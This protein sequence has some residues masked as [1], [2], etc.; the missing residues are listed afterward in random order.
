MPTSALLLPA[1]PVALA[2]GV[3]SARSNL[4]PRSAI[5]SSRWEPVFSGLLSEWRR[6]IGCD[7]VREMFTCSSCRR[8]YVVE[9]GERGV[10]GVDIYSPY[11]DPPPIE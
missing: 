10:Q 11:D 3:H 6:E 4:S 5:S 7:V 8:D 9:I 2:V 1:P